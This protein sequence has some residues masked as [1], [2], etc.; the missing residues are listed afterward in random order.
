MQIKTV[1]PIG[2]YH[3][4][5]LFSNNERRII[6]M[7]AFLKNDGGVLKQLL[8]DEKLFKS[9]FVD[10]VSKS[11]CWRRDADNV[12]IDFDS[13]VIYQNSYLAVE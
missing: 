2:N 10:E 11:I 8:E 13:L 6:N 4:K 7:K 12:Y 3:L 1:Q 9:V 5:I